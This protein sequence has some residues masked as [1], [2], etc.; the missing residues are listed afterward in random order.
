MEI[1]PGPV[2]FQHQ[3]HGELE[4]KGGK[5]HRISKKLA[6]IIAGELHTTT[7]HGAALRAS[8]LPGRWI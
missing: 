5:L 8:L 6:G 7:A 1:M 4:K 2:V 3:Q